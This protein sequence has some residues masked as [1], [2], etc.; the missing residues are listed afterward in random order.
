MPDQRRL[1]VYVCLCVYT[2]V[3]TGL[4]RLRGGLAVHTEEGGDQGVQGG[5]GGKGSCGGGVGGGRRRGGV[6]LLETSPD[7]LISSSLVSHVNRAA[8]P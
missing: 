5:E 1:V 7:L 4:C 8:T 2:S 6:P 3:C